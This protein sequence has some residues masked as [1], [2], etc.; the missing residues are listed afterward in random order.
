MCKVSHGHIKE[1]DV[2]LPPMKEQ[3]AI[4]S[5]LERMDQTHESAN[6]SLKSQIQS[7]QTLRSTLIAHAV[8]GKTKI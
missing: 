7:L 6:G 1:W 5:Y 3:L 8:T 2:A 4:V